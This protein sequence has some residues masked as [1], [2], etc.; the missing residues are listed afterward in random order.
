MSKEREAEIVTCRQ[1]LPWLVLSL[2]PFVVGCGNRAGATPSK[3]LPDVV[4]A[5]DD[6]DF[7][8]VYAGSEIPWRLHVT[9]PGSRKVVIADVKTSCGC[10][11]VEPRSFGL[12]PGE[13]REVR[14]TLDTG[15][16]GAAVET[17]Q[18]PNFSVQI[19]P[20]IA[21]ALGR[22]PV[23]ILRGRVQRLLELSP[24]VLRFDEPLTGQQAMAG[25]KVV[26]KSVVAL[27]SMDAKC[28]AKYG[29]VELAKRSDTSF[30]LMVVP[31]PSLPFGAFQFSVSLVAVARSG[32]TVRI[33]VPV[34]GRSPGDVEVFPDS[35][36]L[37]EG[38]V[39]D[40]LQQVV[41]FR[42]RTTEPFL[43]EPVVA[44]AP[45][46]E[47]TVSTSTTGQVTAVI[48]Q[49]VV[50]VGHQNG[51]IKFLVDRERKRPFEIVLPTYYYGLE[52]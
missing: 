28:D 2:I 48:Q 29:A 23:W 11:S 1:L 25:K 5:R 45:N 27:Q 50:R 32:E 36:L 24:A 44:D 30:S 40:A 3:S 7:G 49:K 43:V 21:D 8:C 52:P 10:L 20:A 18:E 42:A 51:R 19:R 35:L 37:G 16:V 6:L 33:D 26:V 9:N 4:V 39:G 47:V 13:T 14:L 17:A 22:P 38:K 31:N 46:M 15:A 41:E 34:S 12:S